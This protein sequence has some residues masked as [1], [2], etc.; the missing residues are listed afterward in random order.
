MASGGKG[1]KSHLLRDR[2]VT[3]GRLGTIRDINQ[4][5]AGG[6]G[7]ARVATSP[8]RLASKEKNLC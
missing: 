2:V 6:S 3:V 7:E 5:K 1:S 8:A 4:R